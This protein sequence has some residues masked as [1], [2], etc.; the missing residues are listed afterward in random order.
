M[1]S[2]LSLN[3]DFILFYFFNKPDEKTVENCCGIFLFYLLLL[4]FKLHSCRHAAPQTPSTGLRHSAFRKV[5]ESGA[6]SLAGPLLL[7]LFPLDLPLILSAS[8]FLVPGLI[9]AVGSCA[10]SVFGPSAWNDFSFL[11]DRDRLRIPSNQTS[12][13]FFF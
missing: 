11:S 13:S 8:R 12:S 2:C 5:P 6:R 4:F 9:S 10:F 3:V 7:R 1:F